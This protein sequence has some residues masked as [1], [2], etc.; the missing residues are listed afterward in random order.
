MAT[1]TSGLQWKMVDLHFHTPGSKD[2]YGDL[3]TSPEDVI[4]LAQEAG[5]DAIAVTDYN[6]GQ[7]IDKLKTA[8]EGTELVVFPGVEVTAMGGERNAH[9]LGIF[10]PSTGTE[11]VHD[12][13]AQVEITQEKRGKANALA[14]GDVNQVIDRIAERGGVPILAHCDSTSGVVQEMR[15][16]GRISVVRNP[17]LLGAAEITKD[18]TAKFLDGS[19]CLPTQASGIEGIRLPCPRRNR[20]ACYLFQAWVN[21]HRCPKAVLVRPRDAY[22][23][24]GIRP[25]QLPDH[26]E[27]GGLGRVLWRGDVP[28]P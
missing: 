8:A 25:G 27:Y 14:T 2:D 13:L 15:G 21:E 3:S 22:Q 28:V 24:S 5:L 26:H 16:Q 20:E 23:E 7:W 18:E 19:A 9:I 17:N 1:D 6:T 11:H 4:R 12:F 10:D